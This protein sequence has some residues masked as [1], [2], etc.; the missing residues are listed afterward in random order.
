[1]TGGGLLRLSGKIPHSSLLMYLICTVM[2]IRLSFSYPREE[3]TL[4]V[5]IRKAK[6]IRF[7]LLLDIQPRYFNTDVQNNYAG[8]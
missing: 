5:S 8:F 6:Y 3:F 2:M 4:K 7:D 1:M